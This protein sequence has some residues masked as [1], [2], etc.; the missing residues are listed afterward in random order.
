MEMKSLDIKT[1]Y[2]T[3]LSPSKSQKFSEE[4]KHTINKSRENNYENRLIMRNCKIDME[5]C[6]ACTVIVLT[7]E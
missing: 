5:R 7:G 4:I 6:E 1:K 3:Q 2:M